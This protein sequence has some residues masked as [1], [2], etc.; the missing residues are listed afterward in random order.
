MS[1][2]LSTP[3]TPT[4]PAAP[5]TLAKTAV[6]PMPRLPTSRPCGR[7]KASLV[8]PHELDADLINRWNAFRADTAIYRNPF[9][10]PAFT[11]AVARVRQ[12][13]RIAVLEDSGEVVGFLPFH[14]MWGSIGKPIGG[15]INDYQGPILAPGLSLPAEA[16]LAA[17]GI[18]AY[19]YDRMP[20]S[21]VTEAGDGLAGESSIQMDLSAGYEACIARKGRSWTKA[22]ANMRR[23]RKK[24]E[25]ELGPLRFTFHD[26]S[27]EVFA[28]HAAMK[29]RLYS[30]LGIAPEFATGWTGAILAAIRQSADADFSAVMSALHAGDRLVSAHF[31][32]RSMGVLHWWFPSYDLA[33]H[34]Y[35]PG[36]DLLDRCARAASAEGLATIDFG[37]G[38]E[39]FKQVFGDREVALREGSLVRRGRLAARVRRIANALAA[40]AESLPIG[41]FQTYPRRAAVR[42]VSG[43]RLS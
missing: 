38:E 34:A 25:H 7:L 27:D 1:P 29:N 14:L 40:L 26:P 3:V 32:I 39:H 13:A 41:R 11:M 22:Q 21:L 20:A 8:T 23:T 24:A 18:S 9:Y 30:R 12:D 37:H 28:R 36:I 19:D 6:L 35:G 10:S 43:T 31:G 42:F 17:S 5:A 15:H 16:L 4:E 33:A 2:V